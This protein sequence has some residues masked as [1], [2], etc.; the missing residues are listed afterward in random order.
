[1]IRFILIKNFRS[2]E[3]LNISCANITT[4]VGQNDAGKS[5]ILRALNLF[6]NGQTD[7]AAPFDFKKDFNVFA[8]EKKN[9]AKEIVIQLEIELPQSYQ[10]DGHPKQVLWKKT[11][12]Q[13]GLHEPGC[14]CSYI[15]GTK[16]P[17][18]S[19]VPSLLERIAY[20]Y[21]P[22]VKD[23]SFFADLQGQ[24]YDVL[25][26]VTET[27]LH[28]SAS[29]FETEIQ[30]HLRDL[31]VSVNEVF[32]AD[33]IMRLPQNL[34]EI[35]E[36]LEFNA[37]GIP[38]S[39]RGDGVKIRHI[40]MIL[41]F[42]SEKRNSIHKQGVS[43]HIWGFEEPENNVEMAASFQMAKQFISASD[44]G[45]QIFLTTHSPV[46][47]GMGE[48]VRDESK[49]SAYQVKKSTT[50]SEVVSLSRITIDDEMGLM[51]IITPYIIKERSA[52]EYR[53]EEARQDVEKVQA[54]LESTRA[55]AVKPQIFVEGESDKRVLIKAIN[56]IYPPL[57]SLVNVMCGGEAGYGSARAAANR[58]IAWQLVQ[59]SE[60]T[61][62]HAVA[63]FDKDQPGIEA[64]K[65]FEDA[66]KGKSQ[67]IVRAFHWKTPKN[68]L[69]L[70]KSGFLL[71][72]DIEMLYP[73][74]IW[75][76]AAEEGWIEPLDVKSKK[77]S[78]NKREEIIKA[79][80]EGV[81]VNPINDLDQG[82]R[83]RLSMEFTDPGK[84]KAAKY[85]EGLSLDAARKVCT[86]MEGL[87]LDAL[88][89]LFPGYEFND[90]KAPCSGP[91][92]PAPPIGE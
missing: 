70:I 44:D 56:V 65:Y 86:N 85:I 12:R 34:R 25:A 39:R 48:D 90:S 2:I 88:K 21:V 35:F 68:I 47:Y 38:L 10:R 45:Y 53:I 23:K 8:P 92:P 79:A 55:T 87:L 29:S 69:S 32:Q 22:A 5:N 50:Q 27:A 91:T 9:K 61:P 84:I 49:I 14:E 80:M 58:S 77:L 66:T 89:H 26:A 72:V 20:N 74:D 81:V 15:N 54:L 62:I 43:P 73:D 63:I 75:I 7:H 64:K 13:N 52:L 83:L 59:E 31:L 76:K 36:S 17:A 42:I 33:S 3:N 78:P 60:R 37:N 4:F 28:K 30:N 57:A 67:K 1:M 71:P 51:P 11:W 40:P 6:F 46:F 24:V 82:E 41:R 16:F 18:R 19:R